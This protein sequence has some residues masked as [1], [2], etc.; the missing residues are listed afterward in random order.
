MICVVKKSRKE[1]KNDKKKQVLVILSR[2]K[3]LIGETKGH[4]L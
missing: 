2:I 3:I 4:H 1:E